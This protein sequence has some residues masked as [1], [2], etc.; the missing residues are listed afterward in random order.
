M[1]IYPVDSAIHLLNNWNL[2]IIVWS[3]LTLL[4]FFRC[5]RG[6]SEFDVN[7]DTS[8]VPSQF[9]HKRGSTLIQSTPEMP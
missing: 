8:M 9:Q 2:N 6:F 4:K 3:Q 5:S 7:T 1:V